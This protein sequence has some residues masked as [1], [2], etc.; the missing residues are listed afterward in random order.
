MIDQTTARSPA[1]QATVPAHDD[2][3][4][5]SVVVA[6]HV[7][8]DVVPSLPP[9][10]ATRAWRPGSLD[11]IGPAVFGVGG[12]VGNTGIA[13][14]RLG[15]QTTLVARIGDDAAADV[16]VRLIREEV[17]ESR[18]HLSRIAGAAGS[19]SIVLNRP[20][21]DRAI[22]HYPGVNDTFVADDV[23]ASVLSS[24]TLLHVGY[25]PLM[26]A[27]VADGG[28]ELA[29]LMSRARGHGLATSL[30]LANVTFGPGAQRVRWPALLRRILPDVDVFLPSLDEATHMLGRR[31]HLD[32]RGAPDLESVAVIARELLDL[33]VAIAGL[34]L[35]EHGLYVRTAGGPRIASVPTKLPPL[36]AGWSERELH[37]TV[38]ETRVAGTVGAGDSTIAGFLYSLLAGWSTEDAVT[39]ACAAGGISTEAADGTGAVPGWPAI[40]GRLRGG[41]R[42]RVPVGCAGWRTATRG[43]LVADEGR[44]ANEG[45]RLGPDDRCG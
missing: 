25:P 6:G 8:L 5:A 20:G 36:A 10:A 14:H 18:A 19:Y 35:G 28:R 12:C 42:R 37:S 26:A 44:V 27:M 16:L 9:D 29:G 43:D 13:L 24:S 33:G 45:L 7:C 3:P 15:A 34:K 11:L 1:A 4:S 23:P 2:A 39:A 17:P 22:A 40:A 31:V 21:H 32:P 30:D 38:F 41:W